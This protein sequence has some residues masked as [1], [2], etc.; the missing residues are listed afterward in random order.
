MM[1]ALDP[2]FETQALKQERQIIKADILITSATQYLVQ[3]FLQFPHSYSVIP[4]SFATVSM[5]LSPRPER[6]TRMIWSFF[7]VGASFLAWATA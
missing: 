1:A 5:S 4:D 7:I 2:F 6:F 3:D